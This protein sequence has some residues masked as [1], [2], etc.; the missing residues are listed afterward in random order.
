M[1]DHLPK[2]SVIT[3]VRNGESHL[4]QTI[5]SI[6]DQNYKNLEYII[7]DGNST[8]RTVEIIKKYEDRIAYWVSEKDGGIYDAMNKGIKKA[9]GDWLLF[10]NADDFLF[11]NDTLTNAA[12][13]LQRSNSLVAYG[14][15]IIIYATG[16]EIVRGEDWKNLKNYFLNV[17]MNI[18][19][20]GVF[21]S[22]KL[23]EN[24][25]YDTQ[26]KIVADY[27]LLLSYLKDHDAFHIPLTVAKMRA[28]GVSSTSGNNKILREIRK[29]QQK[30]KMYAILPS[31]KWIFYAVKISLVGMI[32]ENFGEERKNAIKR[33]LGL[34][35]KTSR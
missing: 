3:V 8:D 35:K 20:Q 14:N 27:D 17:R 4:E 28:T 33:R 31:F 6:V 30:N 32:I 21:H 12:A 9:T 25:L 11:D 34:A 1:N 22:A 15:V 29:A 18:S 19:H 26:F 5:T 16:S 23:F 24:R 7:I 2:I 10:I 13:Y